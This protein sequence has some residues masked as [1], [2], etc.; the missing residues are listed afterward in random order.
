VSSRDELCSEIEEM[1][2]SPLNKIPVAMPKVFNIFGVKARG[3]LAGLLVAFVAILIYAN[4]LENGFVWDDTEKLGLHNSWQNI[5][6]VSP[7]Y[8]RMPRQVRTVMPDAR[9]RVC[10]RP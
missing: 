10:A 3:Q 8:Y 6:I 5:A 2:F 9:L 1:R 7:Y 4:P